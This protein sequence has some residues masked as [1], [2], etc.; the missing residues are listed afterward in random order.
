MA[1]VTWKICAQEIRSPL[2]TRQVRTIADQLMQIQWKL[3]GGINSDV[4]GTGGGRQQISV[5]IGGTR[6]PY[7]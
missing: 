4:S 3:R 5:G 7:K 2:I 1:H 6:G